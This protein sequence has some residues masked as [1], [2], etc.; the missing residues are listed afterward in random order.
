[1]TLSDCWFFVSVDKVEM[2][3]RVRAANYLLIKDKYFTRF[4]F[5]DKC[6]SVTCVYSDVKVQNDSNIEKQYLIS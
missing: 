3:S 2:S 5:P 1:M 4:K 6:R